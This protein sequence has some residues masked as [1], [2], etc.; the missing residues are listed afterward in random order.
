VKIVEMLYLMDEVLVV[1]ARPRSIFGQDKLTL[2]STELNKPKQEL[3]L[4]HPIIRVKA[5]YNRYLVPS[6]A[7]SSSSSKHTC[8]CMTFTVSHGPS[9]L[10]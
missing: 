6:L 9:L 7:G 2:W 8:R 10:P 4:T 1:G 5:N 3:S